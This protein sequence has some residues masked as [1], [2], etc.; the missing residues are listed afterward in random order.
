M[1]K[2]DFRAYKM[3]E[4]ER[5]PMYCKG[6][7]PQTTYKCRE[8]LCETD[9]EKL[10]IKLESGRELVIIPRKYKG[11]SLICENCSYET[12]WFQQGYE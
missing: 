12:I 8:I 2:S 3:K 5:K 6:T 10:Y 9:T 7:I 11:F 1:E 4:K